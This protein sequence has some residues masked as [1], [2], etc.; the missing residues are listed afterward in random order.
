M[1]LTFNTNAHNLGYVWSASGTILIVDG[2]LQADLKYS[3]NEII[4]IDV[5]QEGCHIPVR[6][7]KQHGKRYVILAID[8]ATTA[9]NKHNETVDVEN[10]TDN[11]TPEQ[12]TKQPAENDT[13]TKFSFMED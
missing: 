1:S 7:I 5:E 6:T 3:A 8:D 11:S 4:H 13:Q 2:A 9:L 12:K 10:V